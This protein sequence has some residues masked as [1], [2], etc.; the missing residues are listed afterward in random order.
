MAAKS[1]TSAGYVAATMVL[2]VLLLVALGLVACSPTEEPMPE[3]TEAPP[4]PTE[5]A[6]EPTEPAAPTEEPSAPEPTEEEV[7]PPT[8]SAPEPTEAPPPT[9][10][11]PAVAVQNELDR[12]VAGRILYNPPTEM[13]VGRTERVEVRIGTDAAAPLAAGL[14]GAGEPVVEAIQVT[15]FMKVRLVGDAFEIVSFSSEEQIVSAQ[16]YTEWAFDVTPA[17]SGTR[18]LTLIVTA[19][20]KA[21]GAEGEK[22]LPI[23]ERQIRIKVN[24]GYVLSSFFVDNQRWIYPVVLVPLLAALGRWLWARR[25]P[26]PGQDEADEESDQRLESTGP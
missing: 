9:P 23:I 2:A 7:L 16:G 17:R 15:C 5:S 22:D 6:P 26:G 4:P 20:V 18:S 3:P 25:R 8:E 10:V 11:S 14:K 1:H 21:T 12:L 19:V 24:P 13:T